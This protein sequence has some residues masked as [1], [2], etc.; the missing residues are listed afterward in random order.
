LPQALL[1]ALR[2]LG[3]ELIGIIKASALV[4]VVTLLNLM[5]QTRFSFAPPSTS[6]SISTPW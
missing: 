2:A 4:A 6:R 1:V 3:N 5:G